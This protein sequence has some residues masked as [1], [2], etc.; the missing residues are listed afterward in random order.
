[1]MRVQPYF[2]NVLSANLD[3]SSIIEFLF[4]CKIL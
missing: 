3:I 4:I 1:L 2:M